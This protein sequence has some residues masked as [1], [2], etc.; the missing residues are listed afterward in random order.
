MKAGRALGTQLETIEG[1]AEFRKELGA[2]SLPE[3]LDVHS[4]FYILLFFVLSVSGISGTRLQASR[5]GSIYCVQRTNNNRVFVVGCIVE[6]DRSNDRWH[7]QDLVLLFDLYC[8][9][10]T[11]GYSHCA[12]RTFVR[13]HLFHCKTSKLMRRLRKND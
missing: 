3:L 9:I 1:E 7:T 2:L 5:S 6:S 8:G 12:V 11:C 13:G 10:I 4:P